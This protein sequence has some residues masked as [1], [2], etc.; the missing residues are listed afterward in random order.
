MWRRQR[1]WRHQSPHFWRHRRLRPLRPHLRHLWSHLRLLL[2]Q[3]K[4]QGLELR[5]HLRR[6][7]GHLRQLLQ[8]PLRQDMFQSWETL[9][10]RRM[11]QRGLRQVPP[12]LDT[13]A[14]TTPGRHFKGS[15]ADAQATSFRM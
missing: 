10:R 11:L 14:Q 15:G 4:R 12:W 7:W 9:Q 13:I 1:H 8:L 6:L 3:R 2:R 5:P